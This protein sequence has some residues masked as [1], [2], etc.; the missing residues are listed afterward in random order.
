M[1]LHRQSFPQARERVENL[2]CSTFSLHFPQ[3]IRNENLSRT[4]AL[5]LL[6][7]FP[8]PYGDGLWILFFKKKEI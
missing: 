1:R 3:A 2:I 4:R 7:A 8:P 5:T 6:P